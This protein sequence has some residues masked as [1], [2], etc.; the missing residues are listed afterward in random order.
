MSRHGQEAYGT[1]RGHSLRVMSV[2]MDQGW[3]MIMREVLMVTA[4]GKPMIRS[5][6]DAN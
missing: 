1:L 4:Q 2:C 5:L 3:E 6:V